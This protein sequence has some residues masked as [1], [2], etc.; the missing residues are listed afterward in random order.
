MIVL[1]S[2]NLYTLPYVTSKYILQC[3]LICENSDLVCSYHHFDLFQCVSQ[4]ISLA[5]WANV[6]AIFAATADNIHESS[7]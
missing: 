3:R 4:Y 7:E 6:E 2:L 1:I 5:V